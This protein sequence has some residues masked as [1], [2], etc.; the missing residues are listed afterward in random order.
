[1][2]YGRGHSP[3]YQVAQ[4]AGDFVQ[5]LTHFTDFYKTTLKN[6]DSASQNF[7]S[8]PDS[9]LYIKLYWDQ[10]QQGEKQRQ[11]NNLR[12]IGKQQDEIL[13]EKGPIEIAQ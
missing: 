4:A 2:S 13:K 9:G 6:C 8:N 11:H 12:K 10:E 5:T 1:M 7:Q 3:Q